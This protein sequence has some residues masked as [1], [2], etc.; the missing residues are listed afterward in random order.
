[1]A[2]QIKKLKKNHYLLQLPSM[3]IIIGTI[4]L[5]LIRYNYTESFKLQIPIIIRV[6]LVISV[7]LVYS[8]IVSFIYL[9]KVRKEKEIYGE[10]NYGK[11]EYEYDYR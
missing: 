10:L 2:N 11:F 7:P 4:A 1:M 6:L 3:M 9:K 8:T 5:I